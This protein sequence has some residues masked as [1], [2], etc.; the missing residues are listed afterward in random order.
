MSFHRW[1]TLGGVTLAVLG[2]TAAQAQAA[3]K[4]VEMEQNLAVKISPARAGTA[5]RPK[6]ASIRVT[7]SS[8]TPEPAT[9]DTVA[10]KFGKGVTF[11]N[12]QFPTC[13]LAT[14]NATRS[15]SRCPRGSIVG[16]GKA[17]AIGFL[18][19]TQ[20]PEDLKVTAVNSPGNTLQ[21]FVEGNSPLVIAAPITGRLVKG[22]GAFGYQLNVTIPDELQEV[23]PGT[24]WA[25]LVYFDVT[26]KATTT[27]RRGRRSMK[28]PYVATTNCTRG[29]WP[30]E[31]DF[32]FDQAAPFI[33]G[34]LTSR[35]APSKCV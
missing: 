26:V 7:I 33:D 18:S 8:P 29:G 13:S 15:L 32:T 20:V 27:V 9:T 31:G 3:G 2:A 35:S 28:V 1:R 19:G 25:P 14:I 12:R 17:R 23:L 22:S 10:I 16:K 30:F 21:L 24:A 6:A 11:N 34:P 4:P 5:K